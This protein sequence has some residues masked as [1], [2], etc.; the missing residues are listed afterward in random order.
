[1]FSKK[2]TK[3]PPK[4][5]QTNKETNKQQKKKNRVYTS[6]FNDISAELMV[7]DKEEF[8]RYLKT[9]TGHAS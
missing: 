8:C 1:M 9:N 2:T 6:A 5:P 4:K 7:N 3:K